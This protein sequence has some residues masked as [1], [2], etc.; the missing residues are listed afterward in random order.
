MDYYLGEERDEDDKHNGCIIRKF[1]SLKNSQYY[2]FS[3]HGSPKHVDF[4]NLQEFYG[5]KNTESFKRKI[6]LKP[7]ELTKYKFILNIQVLQKDYDLVLNNIKE[8]PKDVNNVI[9]SYLH[10]GRRMKWCI[11]FCANY[12]FEESEWTLLEDVTYGLYERP[13]MM[14]MKKNKQV[15]ED[16]IRKIKCSSLSCVQFIEKEILLYLLTLD[17][18]N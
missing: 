13:T 4:M 1:K 7:D 5:Y 8:L 3:E 12:P 17:W 16:K 2:G 10:Y 18:F 6:S 11:E 9:Y 14:D 15:E